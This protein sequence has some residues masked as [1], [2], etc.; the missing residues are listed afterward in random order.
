[1]AMVVA[2]FSGGEAE[3]LRRAMGFK[4]SEKRMRQ[5]EGQLR[6]RAW[7]SAASRRG[8]RDDPEVDRVVRALRLPRVARRQLRAHRLRERVPQGVL[9]G[10][11]LHR[12]PQQPAA[13]LLPSGHADQGRAAARRALRPW[14]CSLHVGV[15]HQ[16]EGAVRLGFC[17]VQGLREEVGRKLEA[18]RG[19]NAERRTSTDEAKG[20]EVGGRSAEAP[21]AADL[22]R[23]PK[24]EGRRSKA[25]GGWY[26]QSA[27]PTT[28]RC[29]R[30]TRVRD[31]RHMYCG[32]C[33]HDWEE[34]VPGTGNRE[35][36]PE[37]DATTIRTCRRQAFSV[38]RYVSLPSTASWRPRASGAMN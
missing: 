8:G 38:R 31:G 10:G 28:C 13:R 21:E 4:R 24:P 6:D 37:P 36:A 18:A 3:D 35:P 20:G 12:A 5:I 34:R 32:V 26:A 25:G 19:T 11:V 27:V 16:P 1:M 23:L 30:S 14:T 29:S 17:M 7:P 15:S 9:P 2:G 33:A 22:S